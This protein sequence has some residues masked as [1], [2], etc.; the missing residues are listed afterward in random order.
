MQRKTSQLELN[1]SGIRPYLKS[2]K[3]L[4]LP[5]GLLYG[6]IFSDRHCKQSYFLQLVLQPQLIDQVLKCCHDEVG[7]LGMDK[8]LE[9]LREKDSVGLP[10][11]GM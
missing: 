9:L 1:I 5:D 8:T 6:K 10:C 7:H 3:Q 4:Q 2:L 11:I